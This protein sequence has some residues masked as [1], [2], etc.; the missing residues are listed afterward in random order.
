[1]TAGTFVALKAVII[2]I[3]SA[4]SILM[5][6]L[7][8]SDQHVLTDSTT[9]INSRIKKKKHDTNLFIHSFNNAILD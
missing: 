6:F 5:S 7:I 4:A 3:T 1:M 2:T 9:N 8:H